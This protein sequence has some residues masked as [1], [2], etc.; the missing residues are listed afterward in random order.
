MRLT[1]TV[2]LFAALVG[3]VAEAKRRPTRVEEPRW[4]EIVFPL[5]TLSK[6]A[7]AK[8][9]YG[10]AFVVDQKNSLLVT[11]FHVIAGFA[12]DRSQYEL[13]LLVKGT[14]VAVELMAFDPVSDLAIVKASTGFSSALSLSNSAP[15]LG[16]AIKC[17]GIPEDTVL[18]VVD[19]RFASSEINGLQKHMVISAPVNSGMSGGP[20]VNSKGEVIGVNASILKDARDISYAVPTTFVRALLSVVQNEGLQRVLASDVEAN[21][22]QLISGRL[23]GAHSNFLNQWKEKNRA[24]ETMQLGPYQIAA[25]PDGLKCWQDKKRNLKTSQEMMICANSATVPVSDVTRAGF[26]SYTAILGSLAEGRIAAFERLQFDQAQWTSFTSDFA[27]AQETKNDYEC[28][29]RYV[30][31]ASQIPMN[32]DV[33]FRRL[34]QGWNLSDAMITARIMSRG[35]RPLSAHLMLGGVSTDLIPS[36]LQF[37]VDSIRPGARP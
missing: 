7:E 6:G 24:A 25:I 18:T 22:S 28:R 29:H 34:K 17:V 12:A 26:F 37:F 14:K 11:N 31:N 8:R 19:G 1:L 9:A 3:H 5:L 4:A 21:S 36:Y 32:V 20:V 23:S 13:K 10:T 15:R 2:V 27:K 30:S 16:A 35:Y 33:C